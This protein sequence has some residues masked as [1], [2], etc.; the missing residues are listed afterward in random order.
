MINHSQRYLK[1]PLSLPLSP[2]GERGRERGQN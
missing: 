2:T 1:F